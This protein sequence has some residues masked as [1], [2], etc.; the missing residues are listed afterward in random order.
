MFINLCC[1]ASLLLL[2][3]LLLTY[4]ALWMFQLEEG[5]MLSVLCRGQ[6]I[7]RGG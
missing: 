7:V 3:L 6:C 2:L 5:G 1:V 4:S